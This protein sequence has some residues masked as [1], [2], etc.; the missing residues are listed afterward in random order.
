MKPSPKIIFIVGLQKSGTTP[1]H[2]LLQ[3]VPGVSNPVVG[4]GAA[5]W[6]DE[7]P[8]AP[9]G[10]PCGRIYLEHS[11]KR[12]HSIDAADASRAD[13]ALFAA[14][15]TAFVP[16]NVWV[17]KNPY[18]AVRVPW[19]RQHFPEALIVACVRAPTANI[20]SLLKK[21]TDHS[22]RGLPPEDGWWG[23]KPAN[24]RDMCDG[25]KIQQIT[26][27]WNAVNQSLLA[28]KAHINAWVEHALFCADPRGT[29]TR[30]LDG[31]GFSGNTGQVPE[32]LTLTDD[33]YRLG[34]WLRSR[35]RGPGDVNSNERLPPLSA[36][37]INEIGQQTAA[38]W[39]DL[40][41]VIG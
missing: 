9:T 14:R 37:Q 36:R 38:T 15:M 27:Q 32:S 20:F 5:F 17:L 28:A 11:G 4:E 21:F 39:E 10:L 40:N 1:L 34:G 8:F 35:N 29:I 33:E 18:H 6:G 41:H 22:G 26:T 30:L 24:W 16:S 7:P 2:R 19:L 23:V 13:G 31:V 25:D 12:G 3:G